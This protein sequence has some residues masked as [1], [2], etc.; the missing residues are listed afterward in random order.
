MNM[1]NMKQARQQG[2]TLIELM[3]VIA[4]VGILSAVALPAYQDYTAKARVTE[5]FTLLSEAKTRVAENYAVTGALSS[6]AAGLGINTSPNSPLVTSIA[7]VAG[8]LTL[9]FAAD[10]KLGKAS[11]VAVTLASVAGSDGRLNWTCTVPAA[12]APV[13]PAE[14]TA[15]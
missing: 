1:K 15:S 14:C 5:G 13:M 11:G 7:L 12:S 8:T 2:F 10:A 4:I 6:D 9:Q 3:I